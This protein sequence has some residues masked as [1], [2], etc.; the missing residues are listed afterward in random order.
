MTTVIL[1]GQEAA[2]YA[3]EHHLAL[4]CDASDSGPAKRRLS[5]KATERLL[6]EH[7]ESLWVETH[8]HI[9]SADHD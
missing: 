7:P 3:E 9:N 2:H 6:Q 4:R 1:R 8:I 5:K